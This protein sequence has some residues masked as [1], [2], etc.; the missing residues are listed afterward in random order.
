MGSQIVIT[1]TSSFTNKLYIYIWKVRLQALTPKDSV[2]YVTNRPLELT[3][4]NDLPSIYQ[5]E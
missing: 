2:N 5:I 4:A 1:L 3:L